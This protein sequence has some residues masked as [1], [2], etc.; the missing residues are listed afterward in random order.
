MKTALNPLEDKQTNQTRSLT[1]QPDGNQDVPLKIYKK[2]PKSSLIP[3]D[4]SQDFPFTVVNPVCLPSF[5]SAE[6]QGNNFCFTPDALA[7]R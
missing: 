5:S 6:L 7:R 4:S 3:H 2:G 1:S